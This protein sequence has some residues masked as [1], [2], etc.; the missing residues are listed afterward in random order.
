LIYC[1]TFIL[2]GV[3]IV[4]AWMDNQLW[5]ETLVLL[6]LILLLAAAKGVLRWLAALDLLPAWR[7][8]LETYA[9]AWTILSPLVP[10]LYAVNF[11]VSAVSRNINWRGVRYR[12]VSAGQTRI[13]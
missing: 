9:W 4:Q 3:L 13:L 2:G 8:K 10:I 12:L 6:W 11:T 7:H 5:L 1:A